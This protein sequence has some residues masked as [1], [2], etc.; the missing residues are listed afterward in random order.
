M[1]L[2]DLLGHVPALAT[3]FGMTTAQVN[4]ILEFLAKKKIAKPDV[5][6]K[7]S[8][9][10]MAKPGKK[11]FL[12]VEEEKGSFFFYNLDFPM[13]KKDIE[14]KLKKAEKA[15][16]TAKDGEKENLEAQVAFLSLCLDRI[17]KKKWLATSGKM[18][19]TRVD[20]TTNE[21]FMNLT[22]KVEGPR[23]STLHT[24]LSELDF[25]DKNGNILRINT[26]DTTEQDTSE[27]NPNDPNDTVQEDD[28]EAQQRSLVR[29]KK[30]E[31]I[32]GNLPKLQQ[33]VGIADAAKV[34]ANIDKY[35]QLLQDVIKEANADG[36][37]TE[38]EQQNIDE[39]RRELQKMTQHLERLDGRKIKLV[40]K[41]KAKV[42]ERMKRS[43]Q[44][45]KEIADRL[46][47]QL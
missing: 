17:K 16:K 8:I 11:P 42:V 28:K 44:R 38:E 25:K 4:L 9:A 35:Q 29:N 5:E 12:F 23:K 47:I 2:K 41:N 31:T 43:N 18:V 15:L 20:S 39:V 32:K 3:A 30:V 19:F 46:G 22:G 14:P 33:A 1:E 27:E 34:Q 36:V 21:C 37:V 6:F 7:A 10:N 24:V 40:P 13:L 26:T 45:L